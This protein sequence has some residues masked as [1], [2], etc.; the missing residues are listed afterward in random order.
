MRIMIKTG[1][2]LFLLFGGAQVAAGQS[3][4][5]ERNFKISGT[6]EFYVELDID[7]AEVNVARN[8]KEGEI[9][10]RLR[11]TEGK[12]DYDFD[13]SE[14]NRSLAFAFEKKGWMNT[15]EE[16][17]QARLEILLPEDVELDLSGRIKAGEV[18]MVL[19]GM[20]FKRFEVKTWAGDVLIDFDRP[21]RSEMSAFE[22]NTKVGETRLK[23]LGNAR[24]AHANINSGIGSLQIDFSGAMSRDASAR[25]DL[26]IGETRIV[27]PEALAVKLNVR[28]FLF[29]SQVNL[30]RSLHRRGRYYLS[31]NYDKAREKL[32]LEITPGI[33]ELDIRIR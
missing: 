29:L 20:H 11:Y 9:A 6:K 25:I 17:L 31:E 22:V 30:P 14:R 2:L 33:G 26:D 23:S 1:L 3:E 7:A 32:E 5:V 18:E 13:Y 21:N 24:F 27:L 15:D 4:E 16:N 28:K 10:V 19:G 12:F 8:P